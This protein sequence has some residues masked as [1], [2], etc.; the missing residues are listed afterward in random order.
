MKSILVTTATLLTA[1]S[2]YGA[3]QAE[4]LEHLQQLLSTKQCP[5]CDLSGS[6]LVMANL[7]GANLSGANLVGAN[8]SRANLAGANLSG[9]NLT[10]ASLNGANLIGANLEGANLSGTDLRGAYLNNASLIGTQLDTAY[11]QGSSGIPI[12]AGTP[13]QFYGWGWLESQRANYK[14]AIEHYNQA[15]TIDPQFA[16]AYL[17]RGIAQ[18]RLGNEQG[19]NEDAESAAKIFKTQKDA[20]GYQ[21]AQKFIKGMEVAREANQPTNSQFDQVIQVVGSLLLQYFLPF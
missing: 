17:A 11:L 4:N 21:A 6:G 2:L 7:V 3:A 18:Y 13:Q 9:A 8:L 5:T 15:L 19:A 16:P 14:G 12:Y 10:G 20:Q 1:L